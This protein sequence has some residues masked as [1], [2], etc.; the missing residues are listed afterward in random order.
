MT[1]TKEY[2]SSSSSRGGE[3]LR[4]TANTFLFSPGMKFVNL[5]KLKD[6]LVAR[7]RDEVKRRESLKTGRIA[8]EKKWLWKN[9]IK[10]A[11]IICYS[12]EERVRF[13]GE[14]DE[15]KVVIWTREANF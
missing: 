15:N 7:Q 6:L 11:S 10:M 8:V 2:N 13:H 4:K 14:S 12:G 5:I 1:I 9:L 3:D